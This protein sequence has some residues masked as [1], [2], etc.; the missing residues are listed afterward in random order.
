M[1]ISSGC[2]LSHLLCVCRTITVWDLAA[3]LDA[4]SSSDT[5]CIATL[6]VGWLEGV[7]L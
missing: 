6:K 2:D 5:L 3:A 7:V 1:Y 4:G